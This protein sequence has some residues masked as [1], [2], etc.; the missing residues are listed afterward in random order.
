MLIVVK[1]KSNRHGVES[2]QNVYVLEQNE[3]QVPA[4]KKVV[5]AKTH[6]SLPQQKLCYNQGW[7]NLYECLS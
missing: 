3:R 1:V 4:Q 5:E 2:E 7:Q 6:A